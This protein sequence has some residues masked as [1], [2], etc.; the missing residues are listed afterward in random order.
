MKEIKNKVGLCIGISNYFIR[1]GVSGSFSESMRLLFNVA[2]SETESAYHTRFKNDIIPQRVFKED[3]KL[4]HHLENK[5]YSEIKKATD[6]DFKEFY[7]ILFDSLTLLEGKNESYIIP[8]KL[9]NTSP[10]VLESLVD[11]VKKVNVDYEM[12]ANNSHFFATHLYSV[13]HYFGTGYCAPSRT[14]AVFQLENARKELM[15]RVILPFGLSTKPGMY[16]VMKLAEEGNPLA[17]YECCGLYYYAIACPEPNYIKAFDYCQKAAQAKPPAPVAMWDYGWM[18][19][20]YK[21][22]GTELENVYIPKLDTM[23]FE[24]RI[25]LAITYEQKASASGVVA[26]FNVLGNIADDDGVADEIKKEFNLPDAETLWKI[27]AESNY[28]FA[29][30]NLSELYERQADAEKDEKKKAELLNLSINYLERAAEQYGAWANNH[31]ALHYYK[32]GNKRKAYN[33]FIIAKN[34]D[35]IW[36]YYNLLEKYYFPAYVDRVAP[37]YMDETIKIEELI[38]VCLN[39]NNKEIIDKT[40]DLVKDFPQLNKQQKLTIG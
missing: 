19:Y 2:Q 32:G 4:L 5:V 10:F 9:K 28:V 8:P 25:R 35:Y 3:Y 27:A 38:K 21:K 20:N 36:G 12:L 16:Q 26:G 24:D 37:D 23:T 17:L 1:I 40:I 22:A 31:L 34:V 15:E 6:G 33:H 29:L 39:S 18:L 13:L 14:D 7:K 30:G 11:Y